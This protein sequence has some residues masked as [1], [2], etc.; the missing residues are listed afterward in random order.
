[1]IGVLLDDVTQAPTVG[2][3]FLTLFQVQDDT[4]TALGL[5]E[6]GNF[7]FAFAL[8]R[9]MHAFAS[10]RTSTTA[11]H[12]NFVGHNE[13]RVEAHAELTDQVRIFFLITGEV[14][15]KVGSAGL[16][17]GTQVGDHIL[18]AHTDTVVFEGDGIGVLVEADANFQ[19]GAAFEQLRLGQ[20]FETQLV[21]RVGGVGNQFTKED[22]LVRVQGMDHEVQQLLYLGLEAQGFFLSFHTHGLQHSNLMAVVARQVGTTAQAY[23]HGGMSCRWGR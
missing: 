23:F 16:G 14:L 5:V 8:G 13:R 21:D 2:E 18:A 6:G 11:E 20:G 19:L 17:N 22:F 4:G 15:H 12:V 10:R 9:P 3:L 7:E 1:M